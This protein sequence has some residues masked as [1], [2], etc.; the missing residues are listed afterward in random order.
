MNFHAPRL[1]DNHHPVV[2]ALE[3][4][5]WA[6]LSLASHGCPV[7]LL[8]CDRRTG[9]PPAWGEGAQWL[10]EIKDGAKVASKRRLKPAC[11]KLLLSWPGP[12]AVVC[13]VAEALE[14]GA[15]ARRG[16]LASCT[17]A[18]QTYL[19]ATGGVAK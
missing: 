9:I 1:D 15:L 18:A 11:A 3:A 4:D 2:R 19:Q 14:A 10:C 17:F 12:G 7:D 16:A 6:V 5:G 8:C 13:S